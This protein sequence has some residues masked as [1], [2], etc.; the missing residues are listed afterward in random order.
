MRLP[1]DLGSTRWL[2]LGLLIGQLELAACTSGAPEQLA[3]AEDEALSAETCGRV[4]AAGRFSLIFFDAMGEMA[5]DCVEGGDP[6]A[7]NPANYALAPLAGLLFAPLGFMI[8]LSSED[9]ERN[10]C[11]QVGSGQPRTTPEIETEDPSALLTLAEAGD[12][13][14]QYK[15]AQQSVAGSTD[16]WIWY[17]RAAVN[18]HA[19]AQATVGHFFEQ[20]TTP[21]K[22]D[23][24]RAYIWYSAAEANGF[25]PKVYEGY[26]K[27][28]RTHV[29]ILIEQLTAEQIAEAERLAAEWAPDP[30]ACLIEGVERR[31]RGRTSAFR[32]ERAVLAVALP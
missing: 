26:D 25:A 9:V 8:G 31:K 11:G 14:A 5:S 13:Q 22:R 7:C 24:V 28:P 1:S 2:V 4:E 23:L 27:P 18:G 12:A 32:L 21:V 15:M 16:K 6:F 10:Y 3:D 19:R 29:E 20:G 17:C 30:A